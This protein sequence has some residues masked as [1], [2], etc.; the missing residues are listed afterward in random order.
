MQ[1]AKSCKKLQV[2]PKRRVGIL[3]G[4]AHRPSPTKTVSVAPLG[5]LQKTP[6]PPTRVPTAT[7][8]SLSD[9]IPD[10]IFSYPQISPSSSL[11]GK[12][13]KKSNALISR[14]EK[15]NPYQKKKYISANSV[16][17]QPRRPESETEGFRETDTGPP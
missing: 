11:R 5:S 10:L 13:R 8:R 12:L 1:K 14:R 15:K 17:C 4:L 2:L 6:V 9:L 7:P 3:R 16:L